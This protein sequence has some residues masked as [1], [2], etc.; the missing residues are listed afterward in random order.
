M[1]RVPL[2]REQSKRKAVGPQLWTHNHWVKSVNRQRGSA[3]VLIMRPPAVH[4]WS[5][6]HELSC[7]THACI[8]V[9]A[10]PRGVAGA[11]KQTI[12]G[13]RM[14]R[15]RGL[16]LHIQREGQAYTRRPPR[17]DDGTA[18][19][20]K[21]PAGHAACE[22]DDCMLALCG[23]QQQRV[24]PA[25]RVLLDPRVAA[26]PVSRCSAARSTAASTGT[27]DMS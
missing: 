6:G 9:L 14:R 16:A 19:R 17:D 2:Q 22:D 15:Q 3:N 21:G 10:C 12:H 27:H 25:A 1:G 5:G 23:F 7:T 18:L 13:P 20:T 11:M 24:H 26:L 4:A 8:W